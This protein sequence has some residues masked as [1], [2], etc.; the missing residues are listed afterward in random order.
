[1]TPR[2]REDHVD[3][4]M[5]ETLESL[6][7]EHACERLLYEYARCVDDGR[8]AAIADLFTE[9]G[10]WIGDDGRGWHGR[11]EIRDAFTRRQALTRRQSRHVI[12]NVL[13]TMRGTDDADAIAYLI[14]YRHDSATGT[15]ERP[16]PAEHPKFVGDYHLRFRREGDK[17][18]I[19]S[20]R[21]ELGFLRRRSA[22][23]AD[24]S[25]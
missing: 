21:F 8:A 1:M 19:A 4:D 14:N 23:A 15:A 16:A 13:V 24:G 5:A 9:D 6:I 18:R 11:D 17:W 2:R 3:D 25:P 7:A 20:F 12:T 22:A 10:E